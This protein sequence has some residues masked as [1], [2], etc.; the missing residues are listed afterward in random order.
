VRNRSFTYVMQT[1]RATPTDDS[2]FAKPATATA[3]R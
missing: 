3:A 2:K 1:V